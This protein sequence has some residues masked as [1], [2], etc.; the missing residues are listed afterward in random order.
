MFN[1][2]IIS[3]LVRKAILKRIISYS[4]FLIRDKITIP[5]NSLKTHFRSIIKFLIV[6]YEQTVMFK[7]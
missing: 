3:E 2:L 5:G 1:S 4:L 7:T 6:N